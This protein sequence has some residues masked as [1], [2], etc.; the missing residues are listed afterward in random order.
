MTKYSAPPTQ[1]MTFDLVIGG[2]PSYEG[3]RDAKRVQ[4]TGSSVWWPCGETNQ[5]PPARHRPGDVRPRA[6]PA[7]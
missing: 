4:A 5:T 3:G 2:A 1:A 6:N 7:A